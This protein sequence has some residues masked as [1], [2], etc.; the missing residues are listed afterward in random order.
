MINDEVGVPDEFEA[1]E[2][3]L[4]AEGVTDL[5]RI[6]KSIETFRLTIS[7]SYDADH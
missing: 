1:V 2:A 6:S 5:E 3:D 7:V 4:N